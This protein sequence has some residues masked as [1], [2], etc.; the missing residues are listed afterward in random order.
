MA[1]ATCRTNSADVGTTMERL[2]A[3][4]STPGRANS[5]HG[6]QPAGLAGTEPVRAGDRH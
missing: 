1:E 6:D 5:T 4:H 3:K 2:A